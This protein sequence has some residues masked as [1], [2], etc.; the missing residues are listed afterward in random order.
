M[1]KSAVF[2]CLCL[3]WLQGYTQLVPVSLP[4]AFAKGWHAKAQFAGSIGFL[5][6][7]AG[8]SGK[9]L[10]ADLWYGY[11]PKSLGGVPIHAVTAKATWLPVKPV[12]WKGVVLRPLSLGG[13]VSYTPGSQYFL[14][15]PEQYPFDYYSYPTAGHIGLFAGGQ[16]AIQPQKMPRLG[17]WAVYYELGTTDVRVASY[18]TNTSSLTLPDLFTL[19]FGIKRKL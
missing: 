2:S 10:E 3:S 8:R 1:L 11:V 17:Q 6:L 13:F 4:Q 7:G 19:G 5:S 14:F 15:N 18:F 9:K 12:Y 16:M